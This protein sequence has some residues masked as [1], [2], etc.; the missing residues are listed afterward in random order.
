MNTTA[1][2][3]HFARWVSAPTARKGLFAGLRGGYGDP[4]RTKW[5]CSVKRLLVSVLAVCLLS[6]VASAGRVAKPADPHAAEKAKIAEAVNA[7]AFDLYAQVRGGKGNLFLSPYS[8]SSALAMTYAGARGQTADEMAATLKFPADWL[9]QA[10]RIHAAFARLNADLNAEGKPYELT[11]ANRLWG[12][13]GYGFLPTFLGLLGKH[14]GAGLEEVDF[15]R[16]TEGARKTINTWVE[17]QTRDKIKDLIPPGGVQPLT[18]LV[19]TNAIYFNGTWMHQFEKKRTK[20]APFT[21]GPFRTITVPTMNQ[22]EHFRH[23]DCGTFQMLEMP[24]KGNELAMAVLLP[25][26]ADGLPALEGRLSAA[27]LAERLRSLKHENVRL[28]L[29]RFTMTWRVLLAGVLKTMG[30]PLAFNASKADF[31]AMNGGVEPLWIDEVIHKA[32]VDVNEE[33]TE[34]AA[35]TAVVMVGA[36]RPREPVIF[37]ADHPFLFLIRDTRSGAVLFMGRVVNPKG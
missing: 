9:A 37:R 31:T 4:P 5:R 24:Y 23:A 30:M 10:D 21:L 7:F 12:Q 13:T 20:D 22:T 35:A 15:A 16:N 11:V 1:Q 26:Q 32:F 29:P 28:Y 27:M 14:Y 2:L 36:G 8:I 34:A 19:L 3:R 25:K 18:R 33:G 17:K 6:G